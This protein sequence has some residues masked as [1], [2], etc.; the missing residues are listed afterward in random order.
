MAANV[1]LAHSEESK[2]HV[3][4]IKNKTLERI[5]ITFFFSMKDDSCSLTDS[6]DWKHANS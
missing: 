3:F 4:L 6:T 1:P 2:K 5:T